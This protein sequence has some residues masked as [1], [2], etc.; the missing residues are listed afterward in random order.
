M[1]MEVETPNIKQHLQI[2]ITQVD[3]Q[4]QTEALNLTENEFPVSGD[5]YAQKH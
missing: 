1:L 4:K 5:T 3:L 2:K